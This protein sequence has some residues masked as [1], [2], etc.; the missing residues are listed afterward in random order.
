M[1]KKIQISITKSEKRDV[2]KSSKKI[3]DNF[4]I[5]IDQYYNENGFV[6]F[7]AKSKKYIILGTNSPKEGICEC[8]VCHTGQLSVI[9]SITTK[10]T[11]HWM[12]E[13]SKWM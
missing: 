4:K 1:R 6:S 9:K 11:I 8:P 13:L 3:I 10:K 2:T 7:S 5:E 12:H